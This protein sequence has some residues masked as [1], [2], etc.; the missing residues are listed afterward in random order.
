MVSPV[1]CRDDRVGASAHFRISPAQVVESVE[2]DGAEAVRNG[3]IGLL[4]TT[5]VDEAGTNRCIG[6]NDHGCIPIVA[7]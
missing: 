2:V 1:E 7:R 5:R 3:E 4:L 6:Q